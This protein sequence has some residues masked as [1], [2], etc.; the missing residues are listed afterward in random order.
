MAWQEL[1]W[2][3]LSPEYPAPQLAMPPPRRPDDVPDDIGSR[4][5]QRER[6]R[7][8]GVKLLVL[9]GALLVGAGV[10]LDR[11]AGVGTH[12]TSPLALG[13]LAAG[14][15]VAF[16]CA[17]LGALW[18]GPSWSERQQHYRLARWERDV[19]EW[20]ARERARY[21]D[22]LPSRRREELRKRVESAY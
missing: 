7:A 13:L 2:P 22:G 11:L 12:A 4:V 5:A 6:M 3:D 18:L 8:R 9:V 19:G 14:L 21:L 20:R 17:A 15:V 16:P 10:A 1:G